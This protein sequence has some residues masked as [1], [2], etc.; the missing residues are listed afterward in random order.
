M[1]FAHSGWKALVPLS[2][3]ISPASIVP[4]VA[5]A[6]PPV[7]I[8]PPVK[9]DTVAP[10]LLMIP[11]VAGASVAPPVLIAPPVAGASVA[12]P[13]LIAPPV[14][15]MSVVPPAPV[16]LGLLLPQP[17]RRSICD[18]SATVPMYVAVRV[19]IEALA[20]FFAVIPRSQVET[21]LE[22]R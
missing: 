14:G 10:P 18:K 21:A 5:G 7:A 2:A 1:R 6:T 19:V 8:V 9:V 4:P 20:F 3:V 11:P 16:V 13:V 15:V 17:S 22:A 12:P